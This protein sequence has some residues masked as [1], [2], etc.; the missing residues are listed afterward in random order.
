MSKV[1]G[2]RLQV[3][4][5]MMPTTKQLKVRQDSLSA[6][7]PGEDVIDVTPFGLS[8]TP[9]MLA[10][11]VSRDDRAAQGGRDDAGLASYFDH[12]R[13]RPEHHT[14]DRTIAGEEIDGALGENIAGNCFGESS[15]DPVQPIGSYQDQK[16][17][18]LPALFRK[19]SRVQGIS[20]QVG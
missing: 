11:T 20:A 10:V 19:G 12:L 4:Q 18:L 6:L 3:L 7:R 5:P 8:P 2:A 15:W 13:T 1:S 9:W 17:G 16:V 14:A